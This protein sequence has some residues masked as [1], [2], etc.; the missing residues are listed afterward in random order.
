M[1][2]PLQIS[3]GN[4]DPSPAVEAIVRQKTAKLDRLFER[5]VSCDIT[6][7]APHRRQYK[8]KLY[9]SPHRHWH[10]RQGRACESGR[11]KNHAHE[12]IN[13]AMRDAFDA[14]VRQL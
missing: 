3:F 12:D 6:I 7:E 8:G 5:I 10:A 2:I 11:P 13:V 9:K 4:T 1:Q 14:A